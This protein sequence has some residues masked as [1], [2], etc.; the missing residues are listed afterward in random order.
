MQRVF[1]NS[2]EGTKELARKLADKFRQGG[3]LALTGD[4]GSGKT[5][6]AQ[7]FAEGL[8]V[9]E[10]LLSPTFVL[11]RQYSIP[12]NSEGKLFHIDLYRLENRVQMEALGL[13]E[14]F[15]NPKNIILIEWAEKLKESLP[16][17]TVSIQIQIISKNKRAISVLS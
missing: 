6:F 3:I 17:N 11:M 5:T 4:L 14:I 9:K 8:G 12:G 7:G 2:A 16:G 13:N 10:H 15:S 1:T